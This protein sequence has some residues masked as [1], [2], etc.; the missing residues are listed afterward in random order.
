M[1]F[2]SL[3][4]DPTN[5]HRR[6]FRLQPSITPWVAN[7]MVETGRDVAASSQTMRTLCS[8]SRESS[9]FKI[10][11]TLSRSIRKPFISKFWC[12]TL[13]HKY[14][15]EDS[16]MAIARTSLS[17]IL[18]VLHDKPNFFKILSNRTIDSFQSLTCSQLSGVA[19]S[20]FRYQVCDIQ[21]QYSFNT[22]T[23]NYEYSRS[24]RENLPSPI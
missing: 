11:R 10:K 13:Y 18:G 15:Q 5:N 1:T 4:L 8:T 14:L 9:S 22:L 20:I 3:L 17:E 19:H 16:F 6:I 23:A 12:I 7:P 2:G 21:F 24:N